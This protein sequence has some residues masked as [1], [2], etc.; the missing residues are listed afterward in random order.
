VDYTDID[1]LTDRFGTQMLVNLTD[2][3]DPRTNAVDMDIITRAITD[4]QAVIDGYLGGKYAL[5]LTE[6]PALIAELSATIAIY[7]L[8]IYTPDEKIVEDYKQALKSLRD[9]AIGT[10]K[11]SVAGVP[12]AAGQS[13][14]ARMTD[15]ERPLTAQNMKGF[16]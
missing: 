2:R 5:P 13:S 9:I 3:G 16:I 14:G 15:R 8:H 6:L 10:L 4:T 7:K 12:S 1:Q 11:L